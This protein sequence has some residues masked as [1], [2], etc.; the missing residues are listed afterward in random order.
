MQ[1]LADRVGW[2]AQPLRLRSA[3]ILQ[4][5]RS[6]ILTKILTLTLTLTLT[7]ALTL[8]LTPRFNA[9]KAALRLTINSQT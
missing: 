9:P 2:L 7:L 3:P 5:F 6:T 8:P 4:R 1:N